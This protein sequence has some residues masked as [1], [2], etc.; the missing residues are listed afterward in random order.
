MQNSHHQE[1]ILDLV[2]IP[3]QSALEETE[4]PESEPKE[5]AMTVSG[6]TEGLGLAEAGIQMFEDVDWNEKEVATAG[7]GIV[8]M[9]ACYEDVLQKLSFSR[10]T[11]VF[12]FCKSFS[13]TCASPPV[14][15][16]IDNDDTDDPPTVKRGVLSPYAV[17]C[18]SFH[19]LIFL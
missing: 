19:F 18:L 8:C 13:R 10:K 17:I 1:H 11:S 14:L 5:R 12:D 15:L 16:D 2:E 3:E 7:Q 9:L 4:E 6:L